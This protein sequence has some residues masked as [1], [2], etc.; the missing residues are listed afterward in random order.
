VLHA[1]PISSSLTWQVRGFLNIFV[2]SLFLRWGVVNPTPNPKAGGP[3]LVGCPRLLFQYIRSYPPYLKGVSSIRNLRTRHTVVTRDP[4]NMDSYGLLGDQIKSDE[5]RKL[6]GTH[7]ETEVWI[8]EFSLKV[9]ME[10]NSLK[11]LQITSAAC[12]G[13]QSVWALNIWVCSV[14]W[15]KCNT[16][17]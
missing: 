10:E 5:C 8:L 9:W 15:K 6:C 2:T 11:T 12:C 14:Q 16:L 17:K 4:P 1:V 13:I 7:G 3:P